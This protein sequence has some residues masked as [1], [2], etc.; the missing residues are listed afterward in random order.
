MTEWAKIGDAQIAYSVLGDGPIDILCFLGEYL[1]VDAVEEE[2]RYAR[3]LRRLGSIGRVILYNP[4]GI[5]L[6]DPPDGPLSFEQ[7][8]DDARAVLDAAGS[9]R[10]A[11]FG[12]N[13]GSPAAIRFAAT[14][15]ERTSAL[16][17]ANGFARLLADEGYEGLPEE[18]VTTAAEATTDTTP[19]G[20]YDFLS[21]MAPSVASD[22]RFRRWWDQSGNRAASPARSRELW[23]LMTYEDAREFLPRITVPTLVMHRANLITVPTSLGRFIAEDVTGARFVELPGNDLMWW[24]GDSDAVLD[25]IET[26]LGGAARARRRLATVLFVDVVGSTERAVALGDRRWR[27]VLGTYHDVADR[28]LAQHSGTQIGTQGDGLLAT[29]D[30]PADAVR[31]GTA[32]AG[33]VRALDIDVRAGVHTGEIEIVGDDVA[34][35]GV[36]I[37]AR[38]MSAAGPGEVLVSRTVADLVTGSGIAFDDR[39]EHDLKGVPGR[40]Q[41]FAVKA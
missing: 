32:I 12:W 4:R 34:G 11:A 22:M 1:P 15:P 28:E 19:S 18:I 20:S 37:A 8:V 3:C 21:V 5:G 33:G 29:F 41:L 14:Q 31:C 13:V 23:R 24:V 36:H 35:I 39:G 10:A 26:F 27:E 40:W 7:L 38:V 25:E 2:P 9:G 16:I 17:I 6:S 30:M